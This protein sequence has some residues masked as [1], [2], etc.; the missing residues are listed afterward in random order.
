[1]WEAKDG[2]PAVTA[3]EDV[4]AGLLEAET[5]RVRALLS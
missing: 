5:A 3:F 2:I 4:P 1:V